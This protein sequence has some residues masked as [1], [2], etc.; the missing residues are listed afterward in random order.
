[1]F[2]AFG[3]AACGGDGEGLSPGDAGAT[4]A[5]DIAPPCGPSTLATG[6]F[7]LSFGGADYGYVVHMPPSY[8]PTKRTPLVLNWHGYTSNGQQQ[9]AFSGFNVVGDE[10]GFIVVYPNS[11]D[12]SWNGGTCCSSMRDDAG[13]ARALVADISAKACIDAKRVYSTGMSNGGFM[14]FRLG[15]EAAD[16]FAAIAP[17]AG[18][19][20][21]AGCRPTRPM[22]LLAI[23]GTADTLVP[24]N[25]GGLSAD[26]L[27]VPDTVKKW[28]DLANCTKGPEKVFEQG[29]ARCEAW[30]SCGEGA[31]VTLCTVEGGGH[32]WPG[33]GFC[34]FG[35]VA[36]DIDANRQIAAF[37]KSFKLP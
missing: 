37:F 10:E 16:L 17:V 25:T 23:H 29:N 35:T 24:Y 2:L 12:A 19:L 15:C 33:Q 36:A 1:M 9:E 3:G 26:M 34:P 14:S 5:G 31:T 18:K 21:V 6:V 8:D 7:T 13:F 28:A 22:P 4:D 11:P 20:G 27:T 30:S 32:C